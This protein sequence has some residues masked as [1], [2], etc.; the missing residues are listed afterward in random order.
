MAKKST[1]SMKKSMPRMMSHDTGDG[2]MSKRMSK[3]DKGRMSKRGS[4]Y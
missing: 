3:R 1:K 2:H 4:R